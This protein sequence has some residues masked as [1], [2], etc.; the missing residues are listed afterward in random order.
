MGAVL[1][2]RRGRSN[3]WEGLDSEDPVPAAYCWTHPPPERP[4]LC[5]FLHPQA[6][7]LGSLCGTLRQNQM[8]GAQRS[9]SQGQRAA[10]LWPE[11][12]QVRPCEGRTCRQGS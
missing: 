2:Q 9:C 8:P 1:G 3:R 5:L 4:Q 6:V 7:T 11:W 10:W 12:P